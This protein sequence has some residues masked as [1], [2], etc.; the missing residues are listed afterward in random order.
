[1]IS[2][3]LLNGVIGSGLAC[4]SFVHPDSGCGEFP[5]WQLDVKF[6]ICM[7]NLFVCTHNACRS[8]L[9]EAITRHLSR[10]RFEVASAGSSPAGQVHS[11]TLQFLGAHGYSS[12]GLSSKD[13]EAVSGFL[14][15]VVITVC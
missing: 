4:R 10:G 13:C 15:D 7:K 12:Q 6:L 14:P 8:I 3:N 2:S 1:M 5:V 11:L 9:A